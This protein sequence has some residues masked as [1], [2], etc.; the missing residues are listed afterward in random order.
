MFHCWLDAGNKVP[1]EGG[2]NLLPIFEKHQPNGIFYSSSKRSDIRWVGNEKGHA[3]VPCY[4]TMPGPERGMLS[5]NSPS[6]RRCLGQGDP[7]GTA[8]SPAIPLSLRNE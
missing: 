3:G 8:W 4:A 7:T 5:H 6:W 2:G 1:E